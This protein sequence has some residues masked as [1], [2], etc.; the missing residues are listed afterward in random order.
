MGDAQADIA[1]FAFSTP[2][3]GAKGDLANYMLVALCSLRF[4]DRETNELLNVFRD[5][6]S[7][8]IPAI[9]GGEAG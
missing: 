6:W 8:P 5:A 3:A 4:E 1:C 7:L 9:A 2:P